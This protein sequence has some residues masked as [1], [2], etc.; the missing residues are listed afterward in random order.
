MPAVLV[1]GHHFTW[2]IVSHKFSVFTRESNNHGGKKKEK[3]KKCFLNQMSLT[4]SNINASEANS[5]T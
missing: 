2:T 4:A 3:K 5:D 1:T